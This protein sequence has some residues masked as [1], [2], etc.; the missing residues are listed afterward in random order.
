MSITKKMFDTSLLSLN[1]ERYVVIGESSIP[2]ILIVLSLWA[3]QIN[4]SSG[5]NVIGRP[6]PYV[7]GHYDVSHTGYCIVQFGSYDD[8]DLCNHFTLDSLGM[9]SMGSNLSEKS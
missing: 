1:S 5:K 2:I 7:F 9:C 6:P 8:V 4:A 3:P